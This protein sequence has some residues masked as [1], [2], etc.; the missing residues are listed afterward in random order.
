VVHGD[1][2][3]IKP[4]AKIPVDGTISDGTSFID[5]SMVTG[6]PIPVEKTIGNTVVAGTLNTNSTF[7]FTATK[8]GSETLLA[9]I[10]KMVE[11][12]QGSRAPIQAMA[13]KISSVFVPAVLVFAFS[14]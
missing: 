14:R 7:T 4:G 5:E 9:N 6:E 11:D 13:D 2:I 1:S 10:I 3:V 12:A 8:V